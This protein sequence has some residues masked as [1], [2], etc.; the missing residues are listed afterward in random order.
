MPF[1]I[2]CGLTFLCLSLLLFLLVQV[3]SQRPRSRSGRM[4]PSPKCCMEAS[5]HAI[6][7]PVIACFEQKKNTFQGCRVHAYIFILCPLSHGMQG[8]VT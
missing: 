8:G 1:S 4:G 2:R 7:E 5:K 6:N 3:T